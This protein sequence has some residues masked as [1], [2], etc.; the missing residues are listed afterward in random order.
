MPITP[1]L[2]MTV[3]CALSGLCRAQTPGDL[4][5][6]PVVMAVL[7]LEQEDPEATLSTEDNDVEYSVTDLELLALSHNPAV[8]EAAARVRAGQGRWF[9]VGIGP[10]PTV[11]YLANEIGNEG[12][13]G[14]HG[15]YIMKFTRSEN[16]V[17]LIGS[18]CSIF[19]RS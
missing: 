6:S 11:G 15:G 14:Q 1:L 18:L 16:N 12:S 19:I 17:G 5:A 8:A 13:D 7:L 4:L 10:N 2:A 3:A 9:Q